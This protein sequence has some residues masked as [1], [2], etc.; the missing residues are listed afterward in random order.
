MN[1]IKI[2]GNIL[3]TTNL[4]RYNSEDVNLI[5]S[6]IIQEDFGGSNDYIEFFVYNTGG[7]LLNTNYNYLS[8]KLPQNVGL[9]PGVNNP[10][11]IDNSNSLS[12]LNVTSIISSNT[13]SLYSVIEIDPVQDLKDLGY[14]SGEFNIRYNF[15]EKKISNNI[16]N[17][18]F[19]KEISSDRTEVKLSSTILS[20]TEIENIVNSIIDEIN[21]VDYHIDYILNFGDN[22]QHIAVNIALNK[23]PNGYEILFKLYKPLPL[24]IEEK[25]TLWVV[26]EKVS[27]YLFN[28]NLDKLITPPPS[29][30]LRGP[31]F[32]IPVNN[33]GTISTS[34]NNYY[35][36]LSHLE[37]LQS[38]S[39][40]QI[41]NL[42]ENKNIKINVDYT[43]FE[44][45]SFFGS[46]YQRLTNFYTKAKQIEDYN[47]FIIRYTPSVATTASLQTTIN[48]YSSSINNLI[49]Q[50]DGYE[51]YLYFESSSYSWPKSGSIKPYRLQSTSSV[52]TWY[53]A[54]TSSALDYDSDNQDNLIYAIPSFVG[55]DTK[56]APF[57][58]FLNMVGHYFD[59]IWI[60]IK[61]LTDINLANNNLE[62][63]I[64]KDLVYERLRSLGIKI[65]NSKS[66]EN[67]D[68]YLIGSNTG[69][70]LYT[71]DYSITSSYLNNIPRNDL[72]SELYK[73]IY[74]NLPLLLKSK[75]TVTGLEYLNTIFGITSSILNVKEFG[76]NLKSSQTK[77]YSTSKVRVIDNT[78]TGSVLSSE[79]SLQSFPTES[80]LFRDR[81]LHYLDV[82]FSPE[83][84][85]DTYISRS[86]ASNNPTWSL[87]DY[88]GDPRQIYSGSYYNLD[89][90][91]KLYFE[92]GV[93]GFNGFTSSLLDY[94][95]FIRLIQYFDNSLFK[96]LNDFV[97]ERA[98]LS[99]GVTINSPVLERNKVTYSKPNFNTESIHN[100]VYEIASMSAVY[101]KLYDILPD[102][103]MP[104]F[105]GEFTGSGFDIHEVFDSRNYNPYLGNWD[106]YNSQH[107][108]SESININ[109]FLHSN[110]NVLLNNVSQSILSNIRRKIEYFYGTTQSITLPAELQDSNLTLK[111][112]I[113]SRYEGSKVTSLF[114]NNYS[115]AS[116]TYV[117]DNSFGKTAAIDQKTHKIAWVKNIP[118]QSLNFYDKT[119]INLKYLVDKDNSLTELSLGNFNLFEVQNTF[120][121]G[122]NV[123]L[124]L[125]DVQKPSNQ[126]NLDG[127]KTIFKGGYSYDPIIFRESNET[128]YFRHD[129]YIS[130]SVGYLGIRGYCDDEYSYESRRQFNAGYQCPPTLPA[131][132][133]SNASN[134][135]YI[136][137]INEIDGA[138]T[139]GQSISY[140]FDSDPAWR[141]RNSG[142]LIN[143]NFPIVNIRNN[144]RFAYSFGN[145]NFKNTGSGYNTEPN[146]NVYASL[147]NGNHIYRVP[148][149][150]T[151]NLRG[152]IPFSFYGDD[153]GRGG[154]VA[155][156]V[157]GIVE[158][159]STPNVESSWQFVANTTLTADSLA[160]RSWYY[161]NYNTIGYDDNMPD[162]STFYCN[163]NSSS[164][165]TAGEYVRLQF[166]ILD[167]SNIFGNG[168]EGTTAFNFIVNG[169]PVNKVLNDGY[170]E[171]YD[172]LTP[173]T[174]YNY[175]SSYGQT[176][177]LFRTGSLNTIL[178]NSSSYYLFTT[179]SSFI[180]TPPTSEYYTPV[181][182]YLGIK[183]HDLVRIGSFTS[184]TSEYYE[185]IAT[186]ITGSPSQIYAVF[187]KPIVTSSY[188]D[189]ISFA[190]LRPKPNETSVIVNYKKQL[191]EV[192]QTILIPNNAN[193][194]IKNQ[195]GNIFKTINPSL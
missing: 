154:Q 144:G 70:N 55:D 167:L 100:P 51:S 42:L 194:E 177:P 124:S 160:A 71:G 132:N 2:I 148:R 171:I 187:N 17:N 80:S 164:A 33:Q 99:T 142:N 45:F 20:N 79:L 107:P 89:Q 74:H 138:T 175:T 52:S 123:V 57:L 104:Y 63:G 169:A 127:S 159:S 155:F 38:S 22:N 88:I 147:N 7:T 141:Y 76:G 119:T 47:N 98:S 191:G 192:S 128:L 94:N 103:K 163:L 136:Y 114:Y 84:Q 21:S 112:Y 134:G 130:S 170:F 91:R 16:D 125:S 72:V 111:S 25:S 152:Q 78:I 106:T 56:N 153:S 5:S 110:F 28:I 140:R 61:A 31:N 193:D 146:P 6:K 101:D 102:N 86:I 181:V 95:G 58:L 46:V 75:G 157:V 39:Y 90:E 173:I 149:T 174:L 162:W 1:N 178:F 8:Y 180:P 183:K 133:V 36:L 24:D 64:S 66:G 12:E 115:S 83:N 62:K 48:Q 184:P 85:I 172:S 30:R 195:V 34:Y 27:P 77:G 120:K 73:R 97:P 59:N 82:S 168:A 37:S 188:N 190:I 145:L 68:K 126:I 3:N 29:L 121:S 156:K 14:S 166:Y 4:N 96:M 13:G 32:D 67:I 53:N 15:L 143:F 139:L 35:N 43:D 185:V 189:A 150:S 151:Y 105:S 23:N 182:D 118:S 11:N 10:V 108:T 49:S 179:S 19:I 131:T 135:Q 60:Y 92:T 113:N 117:G 41:S 186:G 161:S 87:D 109:K 137:R 69:S 50:F 165:L 176:N 65:Y 18:L 40:N 158:K 44:N 116:S 93:S 9:R 122:E 26:R 54:L 81:D 129:T